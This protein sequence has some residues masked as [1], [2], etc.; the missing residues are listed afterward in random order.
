MTDGVLD[1]EMLRRLAYLHAQRALCEMTEANQVGIGQHV[2]CQLLWPYAHR[3]E[4]Y[5]FVRLADGQEP[6]VIRPISFLAA[7]R[8]TPESMEA[9]M[10]WAAIQKWHEQV[11]FQVVATF[12]LLRQAQTTSGVV[13][14]H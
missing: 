11:A 1:P 14:P 2:F 9:W 7:Q 12:S 4:Q 10:A 8:L 5:L 6:V 13:L 3:E